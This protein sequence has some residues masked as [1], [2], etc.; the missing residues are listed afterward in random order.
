VKRVAAFAALALAG[1]SPAQWGPDA[2]AYR[3]YGDRLRVYLSPLFG[4]PCGAAF[5]AQPD[6]LPVDRCF[7]FGAPRRM[8]GVLR[9]WGT[10]AY[11]DEGRDTVRNDAA[12]TQLRAVSPRY[13]L[14]APRPA[15]GQPWAVEERAYRVSFIGRSL[16]TRPRYPTQDIVIIDRIDTIRRIPVGTK[17]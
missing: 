12:G 3:H 6:R 14:P 2:S 7:R 13:R 9:D 8:T 11:F 1:C 5:R 4:Q 16:A 15:P 10:I 17:R